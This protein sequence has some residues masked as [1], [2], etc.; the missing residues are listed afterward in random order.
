[1]RL[2]AKLLERSESATILQTIK[3]LT[4][5]VW[6]CFE[7]MHLIDCSDVPAFPA[8]NCRQEWL[9]QPYPKLLRCTACLARWIWD[10]PV[11]SMR[12]RYGRNHVLGL[13]NTRRFPSP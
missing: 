12:K 2:N 6:N 1:M 11:T 9:R 3:I 7:E 5:F 10:V 13:H 4:G 8:D